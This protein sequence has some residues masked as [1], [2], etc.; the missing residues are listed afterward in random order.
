MSIWFLIVPVVLTVI[1][2]EVWGRRGRVRSFNKEGRP[3]QI[4]HFTN[5]QAWELRRNGYAE[6]K[7]KAPNF[8]ATPEKEEAC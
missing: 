1:A 8:D 5:F 4:G 2:I 7:V 6:R 3:P